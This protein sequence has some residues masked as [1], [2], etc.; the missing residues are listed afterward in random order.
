VT[1]TVGG[2]GMGLFLARQLVVGM[3]GGL[4]EVS[5]HP[6]GG[7]IAVVKLPIAT[8]VDDRDG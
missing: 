4:L 6:D 1:T 5:D 3:H 7:T 8:V 2:S